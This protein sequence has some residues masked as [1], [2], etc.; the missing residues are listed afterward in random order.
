[1]LG[2]DLVAPKGIQIEI[3]SRRIEVGFNQCPDRFF[4]SEL[5]GTMEEED[6]SRGRAH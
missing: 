1:L 4:L 2:S 6:A 5:I 3:A